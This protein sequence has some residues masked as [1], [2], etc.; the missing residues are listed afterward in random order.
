MKSG[1]EWF[2]RID[3]SWNDL[4]TLIFKQQAMQEAGW[5]ANFI[6]NHD[7]PRATTKYLKEQ[8]QQ[9]NAV[10]TFGAMYF[11]RGTFIYQGQELGMTNLKGFD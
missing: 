9:P 5:S 8:A 2:Y 1:S 7:Q 3:W 11:L 4:R 10:K 6:E